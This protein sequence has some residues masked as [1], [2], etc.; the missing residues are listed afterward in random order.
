MLIGFDDESWLLL[1]AV[2]G[3]PMLLFGCLVF[4]LRKR[5]RVGVEWAGVLLLLLAG[6]YA[7]VIIL[8]KIQVS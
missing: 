5:I 3:L 4:L 6:L 8:N 1:L 7:L 2:V